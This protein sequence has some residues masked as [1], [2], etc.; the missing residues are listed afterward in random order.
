[1]IAAPAVASL[2]NVAADCG[3]LPMRRRE[4]RAEIGRVHLHL[5]RRTTALVIATFV[6][7]LLA[8]PLV[9]DPHRTGG[10]PVGP[11]GRAPGN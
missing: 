8:L 5:A 9:A 4:F 3:R 2:R 7:F 10:R 11:S 1:M 6:P